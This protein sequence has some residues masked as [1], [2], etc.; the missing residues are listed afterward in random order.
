MDFDAWTAAIT[1]FV[2]E[3]RTWAPPI[4]LVLAFCE[5]LAFISLVLPFWTVLI[6]IGAIY[7][8]T[9]SADF[10]L[11]VSAAT[12]G[13]AL[14][15]WLSFWLGYHYQGQI[16][17][18]WP[19][20]RYP[21]LL[22]NGHRFFDKWGPWAIVLGRFSGPLRASVPIVAGVVRMPASTF[23]LANWGSAIVWAF[24]LMLFGDAISK[25][26]FWARAHVGG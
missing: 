15:D 6:A 3:H 23:Q 24:S 5:L 16:S 13:A 26:W 1:T 11:I 18:M 17:R 14:G 8:S 21:T 19:I 9:G 20:S 12:I 22:P 4:V 25:V 2:R 10:W 7:N